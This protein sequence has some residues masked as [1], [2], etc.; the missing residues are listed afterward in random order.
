MEM[1]LQYSDYF[2]K[3]C[4]MVNPYIYNEQKNKEITLKDVD[5]ISFYQILFYCYNGYFPDQAS[6]NMY[7]WVALLI[8][9]SRFLFLNIFNYCEYQLKQFINKETVDEIN[10]YAIV[11]NITYHILHII[12]T[13]YYI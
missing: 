8:V 7:D 1:L 9:S 2:Y 12:N 4:N 3:I 6:Y 13:I 11:N 10:E 5:Y